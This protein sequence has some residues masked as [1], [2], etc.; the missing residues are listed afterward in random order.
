MGN[1][2][3]YE[4]ARIRFVFNCLRWANTIP[5]VDTPLWT[6]RVSSAA[7]VAE[8]IAIVVEYLAAKGDAVAALPSECRPRTMVDAQ[9]LNDSAYRLAAYHAHG[10]DARLVQNFATFFAQASRRISELQAP[11]R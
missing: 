1:G 3:P 10:E 8:V 5:Y 9:S 11:G 2:T 6:K 4:P 7:T